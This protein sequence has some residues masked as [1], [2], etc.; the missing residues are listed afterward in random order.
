LTVIA[1]DD[2]GCPDHRRC[3]RD[4][5]TVAAQLAAAGAHVAVADIDGCGAERTVRMIH[6]AGGHAEP[7]AVDVTDPASVEAAV[8]ATVTAFGSL[9]LAVNNAGVTGTGALT[10]EYDPQ[11]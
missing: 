3:L 2:F 9:H 11:D 7:F 6:E 5:A 1:P 8:T 4:R 10:G